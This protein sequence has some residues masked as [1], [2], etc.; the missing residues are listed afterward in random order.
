L[1]LT[2]YSAL[3]KKKASGVDD[4]PAENVTFASI[5]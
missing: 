5:P 4:I 1:T 2:V 3:K